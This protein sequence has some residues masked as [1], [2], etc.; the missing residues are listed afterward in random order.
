MS[1]VFKQTYTKLLPSG[2]RVTRKTKKWYAEYVDPAGKRHRVPGYTDR[3]ATEQLAA[4]LEREAARNVEGLSDTTN[5]HRARPLAEHLADYAAHLAAKDDTEGH[6]RETIGRVRALL[7]GCGFA[8][9]GDVDAG[10]AAGW[11]AALRRGSTPVAVPPGVGGLTPSQAAAVLGISMAA[12]RAAVKRHGVEATGHSRARRLP[13]AGVELIAERMSRGCGPQTAN[14]YVRA[15]RGFFRW[16]VR[17]GR[18]TANPLD[19]LELVGAEADVRHARRE[20]T[21]GEL[22]ALFE[23]TRTSDRSFRGLTGAD[24]FHLYLTAATT[25]FRAR[26]LANL[27]P[28]DFALGGETPVVTLAARFN[29]SRKPKVQPLPP[30]TADAL[31]GYL[32]GKPAGKPVWGGTW[33]RDK[34]GAEMIR[35]DLEVA[36]IA[37]AVEGSDGPAYAD[38]HALRHSFLT[39]GGRSGIDLRTLQVLAG[40]SKPELTARYSHRRLNDLAGAVG[41]L[42]NLLQASDRGGDGCDGGDDSPDSTVAILRK[43]GTEDAAGEKLGGGLGGTTCKPVLFAA[44]L[45]RSG[46]VGEGDAEMPQPAGNAAGCSDLQRDSSSEDDGTRTRNHRIDSPVL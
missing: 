2:E 4:R 8:R 18:A 1:S 37:Y 34:R 24:R 9:L 40:H 19:A 44:R 27:T 26:A 23:A 42:P 12:L 45:F 7:D 15:V 3:A 5:P 46:D 32:A 43:T 28:A 16:M 17:A 20:L 35:G 38:F 33:A 39:L 11:L 6:V 14:H 22:G 30:E 36:G 29:K 41:K 10:K 31:R 25:G 21:A 13:R